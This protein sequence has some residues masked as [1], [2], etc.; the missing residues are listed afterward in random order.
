MLNES[1]LEQRDF[2]A[3]E[4]HAVASSRSAG[5]RIEFRDEE[6]VVRD[7]ASFDFSGIAIALFSPALPFPRTTRPGLRPQGRL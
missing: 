3:A 1:I 6:L 4:V 7:L 5:T 2:P